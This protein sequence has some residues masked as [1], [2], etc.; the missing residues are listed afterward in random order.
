MGGG[1]LNFDPRQSDENSTC[2][3]TLT[4]NFHVIL[5]LWQPSGQGIGS[6]HTCHELESST[7]KDHPPSCPPG[8]AAGVTDQRQSGC[9]ANVLWCTSAFLDCGA[10]GIGEEGNIHQHPA[11]MVSAAIAHSTFGPTDLMSTYTMCTRRV[12]GGIGHR[13]QVLQSGVRCSNP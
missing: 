9:L 13:T 1:S 8:V 6:W 3:I 7:T 10:H 12:F 4:P 5:G 11:P 2:S